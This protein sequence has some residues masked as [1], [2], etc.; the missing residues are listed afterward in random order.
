MRIGSE[1]PRA[2]VT[3]VVVMVAAVVAMAD[4]K[5]AAV[6]IK[7]TGTTLKVAMEEIQVATKVVEA[8]VVAAATVVGKVEATAVN[9]RAAAL[10][11]VNA[12]THDKAKVHVGQAKTQFSLEISVML[13]SRPFFRCSE[14]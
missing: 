9:N 1:P 8:T 6:A 11:V 4:T 2:M 14:A 5:A 3:A 7:V 13:T 10:V 12:W